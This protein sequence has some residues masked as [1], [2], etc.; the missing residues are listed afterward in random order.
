MNTQKWLQSLRSGLRVRLQWTIEP[1]MEFGNH[2]YKL[3]DNLE[4]GTFV[5]FG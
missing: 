1:E 4:N 3:F 5:F 2:F